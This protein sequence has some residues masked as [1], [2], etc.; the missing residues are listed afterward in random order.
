[1][2]TI[3]TG[4]QTIGW[5]LWQKV[6]AFLA[7]P[8]CPLCRQE[9]AGS[10][11]ICANCQEELPKLPEERCQLCGGGRSGILQVCRHCAEEG[12]YPWHR[13]VSALPFQGLAREAVHR[14]K[15]QRQTFLAPFLAAR[16]V[17]AWLQYGAP[18]RPQLLV[19]VPLHW[20]RLWK[21]GFNQSALLAE[22]IGKSLQ[23]PV[24]H[25]LRRCRRTSQQAGLSK[26]ERGKNLKNAFGIRQAQT[27]QNQSILLID[28]VFTTGN[29]LHEAT[30]ILLHNGAAE[31]NVLT[32]A[33]D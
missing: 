23:I 14:F 4:G 25:A 28:D 32:V 21:R 11:G 9:R 20:S 31:V 17:E 8:L 24:C 16:M 5:H 2:K 13:G 30:R 6:D 18:A 3:L 29:T 22:L 15:Y 12:G 1:M 26:E 27:I 33:R 19:P 10:N 7:P